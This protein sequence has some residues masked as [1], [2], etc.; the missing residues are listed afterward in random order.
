MNALLLAILLQSSVA[1]GTNGFIHFDAPAFSDSS[2]YFIDSPSTNFFVIENQGTNVV[3]ILRDGTVKLS[4]PPDQAAKLFWDTVQH[5]AGASMTFQ[6]NQSEILQ[7][8]KECQ[9]YLEPKLHLTLEYQPPAT[10]LR[11][12]ADAIEARERFAKRLD[13]LI[14]TLSK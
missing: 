8:L 9:G 11:Q 1:T 6:T 7:V 10:R 12:E 5:L 13:H 3:T 14:Q 4:A 2:V